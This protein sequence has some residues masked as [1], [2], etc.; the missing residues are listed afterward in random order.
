MDRH[1]LLIKKLEFAVR[2]RDLEISLFWSRAT[3]FWAFLVV[4][5]GG[6]WL[7]T[8]NNMFLGQVAALSASFFVSFCWVLVVLAGRYW[9]KVWE[10]RIEVLEMNSVGPLFSVKEGNG[11]GWRAMAWR[12]SVSRLALIV[13]MVALIATLGLLI[14]TMAL[15]LEA[16]PIARSFMSSLSVWIFGTDATCWDNKSWAWTMVVVSLVA[17]LFA[18]GLSWP[19]ESKLA[20]RPPGLSNSAVYLQLRMSGLPHT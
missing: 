6:Y 15:G 17:S 9:Q 2:A 12:A 16:D 18:L 5:Y 20:G 3:Y 19:R 11:F 4:L 8:V 7:F 1:E 13:S 10:L 14:T